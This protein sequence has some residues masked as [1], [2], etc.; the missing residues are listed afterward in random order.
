MPRAFS[1]P[2][3][4]LPSDILTTQTPGVRRVQVDV[5]Q[6]GFFAGREFRSFREFSIPP[7]APL[8]IRST[9]PETLK[10]VIIQSM[11]LSCY[12]GGLILRSWRDGTPGG[13]WTPSQTLPNNAIPDVPGYQQQLVLEH[14]G[15]LT[16]A[17]LLADV[18]IAYANENGKSS[19]TTVAAVDG[20]RGVAPGVYFVELTPIAGVSV[21]SLGTLSTV[22]EERLPED[23][24][25]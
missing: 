4:G 12:Q 3:F 19:T 22:W 24:W 16:G 7:G 20:E 21:N 18:V 1:R 25:L 23:P 8:V 9:I 17:T 10:G 13:S 14:G 11:R 5:G 6:T 2:L 15:T